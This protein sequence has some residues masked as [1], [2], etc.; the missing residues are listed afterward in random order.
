M[1]EQ[2]PKKPLDQVRACP[3]PSPR[4]QTSVSSVEPSNAYRR[5]AIRL[6]HYSIRAEQWLAKT[7]FEPGTQRLRA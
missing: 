5:D 3:E 4:A 7:G 1:E 2:R 6:K